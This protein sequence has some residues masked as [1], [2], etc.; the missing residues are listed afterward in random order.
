MTVDETR[1]LCAEIVSADEADQS[2]EP[3]MKKLV[4]GIAINIARIAEAGDRKKEKR[5]A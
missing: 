2:V 3:A 4:L 1:A 5:R